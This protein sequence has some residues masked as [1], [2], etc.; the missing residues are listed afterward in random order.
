MHWMEKREEGTAVRLWLRACAAEAIASLVLLAVLSACAGGDQ[1]ADGEVRAP[2][3]RAPTTTMPPSTVA[4]DPV[5]CPEAELLPVLKREIPMGEGVAIDRVELT[6]CRNGYALV[7]LTASSP[8]VT[9]PLPVFLRKTGKGWSVV[10]F[11][12]GIDCA[13]EENLLPKT[14]AAC[15]ALGVVE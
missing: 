10:D 11:G 15:R 3:P 7:V 8:G 2:P 14:V 5:D 9:D 6:H 4:G 1:G 12:T 13:D